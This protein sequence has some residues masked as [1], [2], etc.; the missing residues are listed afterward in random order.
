[1]NMNKY[2]NHT[3]Y[4]YYKLLHICTRT[5]ATTKYDK[6]KRKYRKEKFQC[7]GKWIFVRQRQNII[8][9]EKN[10]GTPTQHN[11]ITTNR[12]EET[13]KERKKKI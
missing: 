13:E 4:E 9:Q 10:T 1:M 6:K 5:I 7:T 8:I 2:P 3:K 11:N 12:I